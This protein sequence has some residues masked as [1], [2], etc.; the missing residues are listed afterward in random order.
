MEIRLPR[1]GEGADSGTVSGIFVKVGDRV[2]KDQPVIELESE[3][4]VAS[5]PSPTAGVVKE[6]H[7]KEGDTVKVGQVILS[8]SDDAALAPERESVRREVPTISVAP[9]GRLVQEVAAQTVEAPLV[10][11]EGIPVPASPS[12]R[13][14]ARELGIDL[15]KVQG[16][17]RGGRIVMADL[18]RYIGQLQQGTLVAAPAPRTA[19]PAPVAPVAPVPAVDFSRWGP[20]TRQKMTSL[21]QT[22]SR[23][24]IHSWLT[25]PHVT[26]FDEADVTELMALRSKHAKDYEKKGV[27][28][29]LLPFVMKAIVAMLRKHPVF[30]SSLDVSTDEI[31]LKEYYHFGVAIDT[32]QG[33]IV[34]VIRDVDKK[35]MADLSTEIERLAERA[36]ERKLS[37]EEMQGGT[38]TISNQGSIGSAHFTPI[39]N[40]PEVAILGVGRA[41]LK[42]VVRDNKV[43]KRQLLPLALS[44]DHRVIDGA[45][46]ARFVT[47]LVHQL[48]AFTD[49]DVRL[50]R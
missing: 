7:V 14:V 23:R 22:I 46:A 32:E 18:R 21:R 50:G 15:T 38:F 13:K 39:I 3:K 20:I 1:L 49:L 4:A 8:F 29:T 27:H 5:I 12:V 47:G 31:I 36:R 11:P 37:L 41:I 25:V 35:S 2:A 28:L 16:S 42:P 9:T 24:M 6:I 33:L 48:T 44:Y 30:N 10:V 45:E 34:P 17:E 19:G 43:V 40:A 26:Q